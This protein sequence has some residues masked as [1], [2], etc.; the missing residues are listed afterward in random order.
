MKK[1]YLFGFIF[2]I[3]LISRSQSN[4]LNFDGINDYISV[5]YQSDFD[6][7]TGTIECWL[8]PNNSSSYNKTLFSLRDVPYS[9]NT[10]WSLHVNSDTGRIGIFNGLSWS[11]YIETFST[12]N[13]TWYHIAFVISTTSTKVYINGVLK[14]TINSGIN[15]SITGKNLE[16]GRADADFT[17]E[18]FDGNIDD[19]RI[20]NYERSA[21]EISSNKNCELSGNETGLVAYYKLNQGTSNSDNTGINT[22]NDSS[23]NNYNGTLQN[24]TLNNATSNW[25][26]GSSSIIENCSTLGLEDIKNKDSK[27]VLF[28]NPTS[29]FLQ[30]LGLAKRE[31]YI[32]FNSLGKE[33]FRG[34]IYD[35]EKIN[36]EGISNG[37]YILK[38][39]NGNNLKF[40]KD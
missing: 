4:S 14:Y 40:I 10:R 20:W 38:L 5:P 8:K 15:S 30:I 9:S 27:Y 24:F 18:Y 26:D 34:S 6:F 31:N 3:S 35:N 33:I 16:I 23:L 39:E 19:I 21:S 13:Y 17:N 22:L 2:I 25:V 12:A 29:N 11:S 37:L 32:I 7:T 36:I 28:Q 1:K